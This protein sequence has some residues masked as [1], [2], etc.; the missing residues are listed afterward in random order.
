MSKELQ[1]QNRSIAGFGEFLVQKDVTF[2]STTGT[3][4]LFTVTGEVI[5]RII[6]VVT[7]NVASGG[8]CNGE[9]GIAGST[10]AILATTDITL[11]AA[12][13]I[14]H[15]TTPDAEIEALSVM[16]DFIISDGNDI[17]LTLSAQADSGALAFHCFWTPLSADGNVVAA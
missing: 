1:V 5:V 12:R 13:E 2:S 3:V 8:G 14:W 15:D 16:K 10:A 17:V 11:L 7:T 9:V 4:N 6:A